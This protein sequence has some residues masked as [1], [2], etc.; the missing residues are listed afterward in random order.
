MT[1]S[2]KNIA[3]TNSIGYITCA[4]AANFTPLRLTKGERCTAL[5]MCGNLKVMAARLDTVCRYI[6]EKSGWTV[7]NLQLQKLLYLSQMIYIG[8]SGG[9]RL[10]DADFEAWDYGPVEPKIY[11][12]VRMFGKDRIKDVFPE[13]RNFADGDPRSL[14]IDE[15]C[16]DLLRRRAGELVELTHWDGGAWAKNYVPGARGVKI[17]DADILREYRDRIACGNL[18]DNRSNSSA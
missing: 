4:W 1:V 11:K 2:R 5:L 3:R 18:R 17:P 6:C 9:N 16:Q 10:A 15:L 12:K 7:T 8:R 13:A 14:L